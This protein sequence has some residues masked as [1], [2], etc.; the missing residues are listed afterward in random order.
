MGSGFPNIWLLL[1]PSRDSAHEQYDFWPKRVLLNNAYGRYIVDRARQLQALD[2][3]HVAQY[4]QTR[5]AKLQI[6]AKWGWP[7]SR[8]LLKFCTPSNISPKRVKLQT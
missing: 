1:T 3:W 5:T 8:D 2:I 6:F 7:T 4:R